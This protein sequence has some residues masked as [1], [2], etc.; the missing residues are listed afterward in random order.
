[1]TS[2]SRS[3]RTNRGRER[4]CLGRLDFH[5]FCLTPRRSTQRYVYL[6]PHGPRCSETITPRHP[7]SRASSWIDLDFPDLSRTSRKPGDTKNASRINTHIDRFRG[8]WN[9]SA[10]RL[11]YYCSGHGE[12][13]PSHRAQPLP[14]SWEMYATQDMG[15]QQEYRRLRAI[16]CASTLHRLCTSCHRPPNTYLRTV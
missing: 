14:C 5:P 4:T 8:R 9:L 13:T 12:C 2:S 11:V 1:M 15:T 16:Y 3:R 7:E 6:V 10:M